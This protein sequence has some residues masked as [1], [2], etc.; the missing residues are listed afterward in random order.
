[1]SEER[2]QHVWEC[3]VQELQTDKFS[4]TQRCLTDPSIPE[5]YGSFRYDAVRVPDRM[6]CQPGMCFYWVD[7]TDT[8]YFRKAV[9]TTEEI[10]RAKEEGSRMANI[11]GA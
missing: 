8:I 6:I 7:G 10:I 3:T 1:M 4:A 11:Y 2:P 5:C 9:W